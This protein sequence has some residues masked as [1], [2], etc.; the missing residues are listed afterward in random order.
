[1]AW[2]KLVN[3]FLHAVTQWVSERAKRC[4]Q[5]SASLLGRSNFFQNGGAVSCWCVSSGGIQALFQEKAEKPPGLSSYGEG[6][7]C[8]GT[9]LGWAHN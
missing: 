3:Q 8:L 5:I 1:M 4:D 7:H 6:G 2:L 9:H